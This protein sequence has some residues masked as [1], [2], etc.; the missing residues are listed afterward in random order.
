MRS[1]VDF[2]GF[3]WR[4]CLPEKSFHSMDLMMSALGDVFD[5]WCQIRFWGIRSGVGSRR[6]IAIGV[7]QGRSSRCAEAAWLLGPEPFDLGGAGGSS[8]GCRVSQEVEDTFRKFATGE[9]SMRY[10]AISFAKEPVWFPLIKK[11]FDR[12]AADE[13]I[14]QFHEKC[15]GRITWL[16]TTSVKCALQTW[17]SGETAIPW[18]RPQARKS[19]LSAWGADL[20]PYYFAEWGN[21][22]QLERPAVT[23]G[24]H[25]PDFIRP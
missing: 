20:M 22:P 8:C 15:A 25:R 6:I 10:A 24:D 19:G 14:H 7:R 11:G 21:S 5:S 23:A 3:Q 13:G 17:L 12:F 16:K 4:S 9:A 18:W 1:S 2:P